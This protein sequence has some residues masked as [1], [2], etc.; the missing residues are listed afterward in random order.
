LALTKRCCTP[1][2][3]IIQ[4]HAMRVC[5]SNRCV[6]VFWQFFRRNVLVVAWMQVSTNPA[7]F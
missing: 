5:P 3:P 2:M 7:S 6:V 1:P 4:V